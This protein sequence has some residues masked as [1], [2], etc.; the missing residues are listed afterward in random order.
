MQAFPACKAEASVE[1]FVVRAVYVRT[2]I[3]YI[4]KDVPRLDKV[5]G[6]F[7]SRRWEV[8]S[9]ARSP[10]LLQDQVAF[11]FEVEFAVFHR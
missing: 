9:S 2:L 1:G 11:G 8:I 7:I 4:V 10:C 5:S 3:E 6:K